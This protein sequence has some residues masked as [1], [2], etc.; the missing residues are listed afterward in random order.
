MK[1]RLLFILLVIALS[2]SSWADSGYSF[3][4]NV[5]EAGNL[6]EAI[7]Y[8]HTD[9]IKNLTIIGKLNGTDFKYLRSEEIRNYAIDSLDIRDVMLIPGGESYYT[10][11]NPGGDGDYFSSDTYYVYLSDHDA[12]EFIDASYV[13]G[14]QSENR[15]YS[16]ALPYAFTNTNIKYVALPNQL[17]R[18]G[19]GMF[20]KS[21]TE[22]VVIPERVTAIDADAFFR[23]S[24]LEKVNDLHNIKNIGNRAFSEC[25]KLSFVILDLNSST[26]IGDNAFYSCKS[27]KSVKFGDDLLSVGSSAFSSCDA[28]TSIS[29]NP[30]IPTLYSRSSFS[31]S[32]INNLPVEDGIIYMG[33]TALKLKNRNGDEILP[34]LKFRE[35]T[36]AIAHDFANSVYYSKLV[37]PESLKRIGDRAFYQ[38]GGGW[39]GDYYIGIEEL[40]LPS[41]LE[42]IGVETFAVAHGIKTLTIP[43]SVKKIE[44]SA[45]ADCKGL[46]SLYYIGYGQGS[47]IFYRCSELEKVTIGSNVLVLSERIFDDCEKLSEIKFEERSP[48]TR[49]NIR[50][51]AFYGCKA[52]KSFIA[53]EGTDTIGNSVFYQCEV[54]EKIELPMSLVSIGSSAFGKCKALTQIELP[55]H[56]SYIG[57][58]AFGDCTSLTSIAIPEEVTWEKTVVDRSGNEK[59]STFFSGCTNLKLAT[60]N[61]KDVGNWLRSS[62]ETV[63]LSANTEYVDDAF[64]YCKDLKRVYCYATKLPSTTS[65]AFQGSPIQKDTLYVPSQSI[66]EYKSTEPWS[67]FKYIIAIDGNSPSNNTFKAYTPQG[68]EMTFKVI[69]EDQKLVQV[70]TGEQGQPAMTASD[71]T[72]LIIPE[73][74]NGYKVASI[75]EYAFAGFTNLR[76]VSIPWTAGFDIYIEDPYPPTRIYSMWVQN[77]AFSGCSNLETVIMYADIEPGI[78]DLD[79]S[80]H[81]IE[82]YVFDAIVYQNATLYVPYGYKDRFQDK[83]KTTWCEFKHI[84]EYSGEVPH[85]NDS[86]NVQGSITEYFIDKDP[87]YGK[88][89]VVKKS[90]DGE[91]MME[92]DLDDVK[93]GAHILYVRIRDEQGRWS[94][95]VNRPLYVRQPVSIVALEYF[96]DNKDPGQGKGV[97]V[98]PPTDTSKPYEFEISLG[99]LSAGEHSLNVRAKGSDGIWTALKGAL[100]TLVN[101]TGINDLENYCEPSIIYTLYGYKGKKSKGVNI[102]RY[103]D[104]TTKKVIVK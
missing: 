76:S 29:Y 64:R 83:A 72:E 70:G 37:L 13:L 74:I 26:E 39:M 93:P 4:V 89:S 38:G 73:I 90:E 68:V 52:L 99:N 21:K 51:K 3:T 77:Y 17:K 33:K 62:L 91:N 24:S 46:S 81:W 41:G 85:N 97:K 101:N 11:V 60:I 61:C 66:Q 53:P 15:W 23:C 5:T 98:K 6:E 34:G 32:W 100:F 7:K 69:D 79:Y 19:Q 88:A 2:I 67:N 9:S 57:S 47:T 20:D 42:E 50:N 75:G 48:E 16:D 80:L 28:L 44:K 103:N 30:D 14:V 12:L 43:K 27:I 63:I 94:T 22:E 8:L 95:T 49:L 59:V 87:G 1:Q 71:I 84:E 78:S 40:D 58:G 86:P 82:E 65:D 31:D 104:G 10:Y 55:N 56:L 92:I 35:G 25:G 36:L 45:F 18:I 54:M 102:I 96:F